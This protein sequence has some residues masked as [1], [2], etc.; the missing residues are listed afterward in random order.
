MATLIEAKRKLEQSLAHGAPQPDPA[1]KRLSLDAVGEVPEVFQHR[2]PPDYHSRKHVKA[3]ART[4]QQRR[5][6][7]PVTVYWVGNGWVCVDGHHRLKAYQLAKWKGE[8]PVHVFNGTLDQAIGL[9][10]RNARDKLPMSHSEKMNATWRLVVGTSLSRA[11]IIRETGAGD[12]TVAHM[13]RVKLSLLAKD[14]QR[15][16]SSE[17][18]Y[19][20]L[21]EFQGQQQEKPEEYDEQHTS[22][23][24]QKFAN[25]IT[26]T[27]GKLKQHHFEAFAEA[28]E[29]Y[30]RRLPEFLPN[31]WR[32]A[33]DFRDLEQE[34]E[35]EF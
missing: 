13:R 19:H 30:H 28:L 8:I 4:P 17:N 10:A 12:G 1:P 9:A 20:A 25:A 7:R 29:I 21:R 18:W 26:K 6:L 23:L 31:Y 14:P 2:G 27:L 3:L 22:A 24:A 35:E 11:E 33:S 34:G 15:D 32:E 16:L 5:T